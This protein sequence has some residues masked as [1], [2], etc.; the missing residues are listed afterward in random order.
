MYAAGLYS[1]FNNYSTTCSNQ[2]GPED[3]QGDTFSIEGRVDDLT[4]YTLSTIGTTDMV[5]LDG[6]AV[7][8]YS[9]NV[10]TFAD[11]IAYFS[12]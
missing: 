7:A 1:F 11:T 5:T 10:A 2:N 12:V 8:K 9:D 6:M 3:C 4:V